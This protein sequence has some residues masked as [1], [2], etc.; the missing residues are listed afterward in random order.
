[1]SSRA[2][3]LLV[4]RRWW[5]LTLWAGACLALEARGWSWKL[6]YAGTQ[7]F[8]G[9][10]P[11]HLPGPGGLHI[12]AS[13]P[14]LQT[15]PLTFLAAAPLIPLGLDRSFQVAAIGMTLLGLVILR[16]LQGWALDLAGEQPARSRI[17]T[18]TLVGG[19][20][21]V[22]AWVDLAAWY[23][24]L[25]DAMALAFAV[26]AVRAT[27]ARKPVQLGLML[28]L[29]VIA[30]PVAIGFL[31]LVL[32]LPRRQWWRAVGVVAAVVGIAAAPFLVAD[33]RTLSA[34]G[35]FRIP[36]EAGS[37]LRLFGVTAA[38]TPPWDRPLQL[39]LA[40]ALGLV[41]VRRGRWPAVLLLAVDAR[42][43]LDPSVNAY[44]GAWLLVG[45]LAWDLWRAGG[46]GSRTGWRAPFTLVG[47]LMLLVP[48]LAPVA[49]LVG[50]SGRAVLRA[51]FLIGS[52]V[53]VLVGP[54]RSELV[55]FSPGSA[56]GSAAVSSGAAHGRR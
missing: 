4:R 32:V 33:P 31:P 44:Y 17:E 30:K 38:A 47:F 39:L 41:A 1:M 27:S 21:F 54:G 28:G 40:W 52:A 7:L 2:W 23:G 13:E 37:V 56:V 9:G 53:A 48:G 8:L 22:P 3:H 16:L 24:H 29:A 51:G 50:V 15:G 5:V 45:T 42:I 46:S 36:V 20:V 43:L 14:Q 19:L 11:P 55:P 26:L 49:S 18:A 35:G 12:Y 25:D 34:A 10:H 6:F